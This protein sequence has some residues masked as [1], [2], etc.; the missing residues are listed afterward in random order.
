MDIRS[1][2]TS[3]SPRVGDISGYVVLYLG[4][5]WFFW[6]LILL[7]GE[8]V[9]TFPNVLF[10][11]IGSLSPAIGGVSMVYRREGRAG[12]RTL[13]DRIANVRRVNLRW[14]AVVFLLFPTLTVLAAAIATGVGASETPLLD[15]G[16]LAERL[17]NPLGLIAFLGFTFGAGLVEETGKVGYFLD[18]LMDRFDPISAGLISG[19]VWAVWHVPLFLMVGYF[20]QAGFEPVV[21]RFFGTFVFLEVLLAWIY[22]NTDRSVLAAIVFHTVINLNGEALGPSRQV[23]GYLFFLTVAVTV[24]IVIWWRHRVRFRSSSPLAK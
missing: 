8:S 14:Y 23:R 24:I 1:N 20:S 2:I 11:Y 10:F 17:A 12:L 19:V 7:S 9:W 16:S 21:W 13:W 3:V 15:T 5:A 22:H 6:G 18:R 4:W